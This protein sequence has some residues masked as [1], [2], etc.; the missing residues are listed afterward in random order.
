MTHEAITQETAFPPTLEGDIAY[1]E[2]RVDRLAAEAPAIA[3]TKEYPEWYFQDNERLREILPQ[4]KT[5]GADL[6]NV[7]KYYELSAKEAELRSTITGYPQYSHPLEQLAYNLGEDLMGKALMAEPADGTIRT[8]MIDDLSQA[9]ERTTGTLGPELNVLKEAYGVP[10]ATDLLG[11]GG[12]EY[13]DKIRSLLLQNNAI[14]WI[15]FADQERKDDMTWHETQEASRTWMSRAAEAATGIPA[16]EALDY[17]FTASRR[18]EDADIISIIEKFDH[19]GVERVRELAKATGIHGLEAYSTE[20]LE[21]ME[22]FVYDPTKVA[23]RLAEHDV[24][25]VMVNRVGDHNG[26]MKNVAPDFDDDNKRVLFF[27]INRM[28]D[29]YRRMVTLRKAGV[30]P[31]TLV[32]AAHSAPGQFTV[33]DSREKS[34]RR[35]DIATVAGRK[36]V[37]MVHSNGDLEPGDLGYSMHG[38]KGMARLVETYMQPSRAIDDNDAD[39]GREKIIFQA[40]HG[41][42]EVESGDIDEY[43]EKVQIGMQSVVSQLGSDLIASGVKTNIDIYGAPGGIQLHRNGRGVYYTGQPTSFDQALEGRP[44]LSAMRVRVEDG[45][46]DKQEVHDI[47]LRK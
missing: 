6:G 23:E 2:Q 7:S 37:A 28:D 43:G 34:S 38:M 30:K 44:H 1:W 42:S 26:V 46:L 14:K 24:I 18:G 17:V 32:L 10:T 45:R 33:S 41:A 16:D 20:Q 13:S 29:I 39:K 25:A 8:A 3:G 27:E 15:R 47:T 19:F 36:L 31:S 12:D 40:C 11:I 21:L 5:E 9:V 35:R 22:E 4:L